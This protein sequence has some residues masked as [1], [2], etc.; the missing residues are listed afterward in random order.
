MCAAALGERYSGSD[1]A[2]AA[3][4]LG[5]VDKELGAKLK[6]LVDLKPGA[7]YGNALLTSRQR[8]AAFRAAEAL[9]AAAQERTT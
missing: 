2:A 1:H 6:A 9:V 3:A 7:H 5:R 8:T 4:L